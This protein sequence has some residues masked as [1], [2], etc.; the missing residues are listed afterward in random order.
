MGKKNRPTPVEVHVRSKGKKKNIFQKILRSGEYYILPLTGEMKTNLYNKGILDGRKKPIRLHEETEDFSRFYRFKWLLGVRKSDVEAY[1]TD[2]LLFT[3]KLD[4]TR[5]FLIYTHEISLI[6][7]RWCPWCEECG[8]NGN[9]FCSTI[10]RQ[11]FVLGSKYSG[12]TL[13]RWTYA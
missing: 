9:Y 13:G 8:V 12:G 5:T 4:I 1:L 7:E 10:P 3:Y 6:E 11:E 2:Q